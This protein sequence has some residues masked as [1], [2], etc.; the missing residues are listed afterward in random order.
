MYHL[1]GGRKGILFPICQYIKRGQGRGN[2][3]GE[4]G[5]PAAPSMYLTG[6]WAMNGGGPLLLRAFLRPHAAFLEDLAFTSTM[7]SDFHSNHLLYK[8]NK[9][10]R[11][12][13]TCPKY[14]TGKQQSQRVNPSCLTPKP[15][16]PQS[17]RF[18]P[19]PR[20]SMKIRCPVSREMADDSQ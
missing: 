13:A 16:S 2:E 3:Q 1:M 5:L 12:R 20:S 6:L 18:L 14:P 7:A 19:Y 8:D 15:A 4:L 9:A 10:Q 17:P 11:E